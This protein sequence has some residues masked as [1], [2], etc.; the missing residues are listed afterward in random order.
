MADE[1]QN[2]TNGSHGIR[3]P[4][5][6]ATQTRVLRTKLIEGGKQRQRRCVICGFQNIFT[7]E[8]YRIRQKS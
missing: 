2:G 1:S 7:T 4:K 5:C 3:C 6:K 8:L